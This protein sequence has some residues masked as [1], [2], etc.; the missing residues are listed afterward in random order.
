M[1]AVPDLKD[2]LL[3]REFTPEL[4][5]SHDVRKEGDDA[6]DSESDGGGDDGDDSDDSDDELPVFTL[7]AGR[8]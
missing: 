8:A 4:L 7:L 3:L 1:H 2:R 5:T 6:D